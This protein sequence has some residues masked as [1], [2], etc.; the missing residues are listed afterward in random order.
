MLLYTQLC[1][2][3]FDLFQPDELSEAAFAIKET[4]STAGNKEP[5]S[6]CHYLHITS[7][8]FGKGFDKARRGDGVVAEAVEMAGNYEMWLGEGAPVGAPPRA[9]LVVAP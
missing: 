5:V 7:S 6:T 2:A 1:D 9:G 8:L 4:A 3:R